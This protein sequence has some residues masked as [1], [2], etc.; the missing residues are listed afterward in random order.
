MDPF[1]VQFSLYQFRSY[2][3]CKLHL[4]PCQTSLHNPIERNS[5]LERRN[6]NDNKSAL[7][8][9]LL[10]PSGTG[11]GSTQSARGVWELTFLTFKLCSYISLAQK[12]TLIKSINFVTFS[13]GVTYKLYHHPSISDLSIKFLSRAGL[14][15][16]CSGFLVLIGLLLHLNFK[17]II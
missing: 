8:G 4:S 9:K 17:K 7:E 6:L 2:Q 1:I 15:L 10:S 3:C 12:K 5:N 14:L 11:Q 16:L 13:C